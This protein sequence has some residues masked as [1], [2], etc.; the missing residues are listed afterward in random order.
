MVSL[1]AVV[2][3]LPFS[4]AFANARGH[5]ARERVYCEGQSKTDAGEI[6]DSAACRYGKDTFDCG[7]VRDMFTTGARGAAAHVMYAFG[8]VALTICSQPLS[9]VC[10]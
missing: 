3:T 10:V 1:S 8:C 4:D 9:V 5:A 2:C 6:H 7:C